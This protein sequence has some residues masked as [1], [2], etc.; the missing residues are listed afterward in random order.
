[1]GIPKLVAGVSAL[2]AVTLLAAPTVPRA[3][4]HVSSAQQA[5]IVSTEAGPLV[6]AKPTA[7]PPRSAVAVVTET[8]SALTCAEIRSMDE[9]ELITDDSYC[10]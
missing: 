5:A 4:R 10:K 6:E 9:V 8:G 1:M 7:L 3:G 2:L